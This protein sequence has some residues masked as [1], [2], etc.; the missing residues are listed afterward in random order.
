MRKTLITLAIIFGLGLGAFAQGGGL[1]QYGE[2]NEEDYYGSVWYSLDQNITLRDFTMPLLPG[3]GANTNQDAAP[4]GGGVLL[5]IGFGA[6][7]AM[8]KRK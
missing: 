6:A 4:L 2:V 1:F 7:Y 3:H 8:K 5:L